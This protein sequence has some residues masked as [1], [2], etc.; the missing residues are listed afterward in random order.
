MR[1]VGRYRCEAIQC[2]EHNIRTT[3]R[4][5]LRQPW[6]ASPHFICTYR[7]CGGGFAMTGR[8]KPCPVPALCAGTLDVGYA[9]RARRASPLHSFCVDCGAN[10]RAG[11]KPAPTFIV[12][13][14]S[15]VP[16]PRPTF[17]VPRPAP[18]STPAIVYET[19]TNR[20]LNG[21]CNLC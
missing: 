15:R 4:R 16:P 10:K 21:A 20:L 2:R 8:A 14:A 12:R 6:I 17:H 11:L 5:I 3:Y 18:A 7:E 9:I 1:Y 19:F 13:P